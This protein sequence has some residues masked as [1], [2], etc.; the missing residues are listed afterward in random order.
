MLI[1]P[2]LSVVELRF[3]EKV[4]QLMHLH[5]ESKDYRRPRDHQREVQVQVQI[6]QPISHT[7]RSVPHPLKT[8]PKLQPEQCM[9][10]ATMPNIQREGKWWK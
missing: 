2:G 4:T 8:L 5:Q 1:V 3:V 9:R 7:H 10:W 6:L